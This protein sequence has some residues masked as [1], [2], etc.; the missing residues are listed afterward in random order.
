MPGRAVDVALLFAGAAR[1]PLLD[2]TLTLTSEEA[3]EAARLLAPATI[4]PVH[5][6][7]WA[8]FTE[9]PEQLAKAF[10]TANL[11]DRLR[12]PVAGVALDL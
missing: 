11:A 7:G 5:T 10:T 3:V 9:G 6:E 12:I 2:A 4:V 8:H 1:T